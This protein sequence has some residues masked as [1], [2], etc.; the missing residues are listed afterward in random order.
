MDTQTR[1]SKTNLISG[2]THFAGV[3]HTCTALF[4]YQGL[5]LQLDVKQAF[6]M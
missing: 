6:I 5:H 3:M 4:A 1:G 2:I